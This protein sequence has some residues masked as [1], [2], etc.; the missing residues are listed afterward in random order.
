MTQMHAAAKMNWP[1]RSARPPHVPGR[2]GSPVITTASETP[3]Y[4]SQKTLR[5]LAEQTGPRCTAAIVRGGAAKSWSLFGPLLEDEGEGV[6]NL[7]RRR[8]GDF[9]MLGRKVARVWG[10]R[11]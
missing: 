6:G 3:I 2:P 11:R 4:A 10:R 8:R 1:A 7:R 9:A 5:R